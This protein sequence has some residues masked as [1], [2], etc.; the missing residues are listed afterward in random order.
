RKGHAKLIERTAA[1]VGQRQPSARGVL[2]R[3]FGDTHLAEHKILTRLIERQRRERKIATENTARGW[4]SLPDGSRRPLDEFGVSFSASRA[5]LSPLFTAA[6]V[7]VP[8]GGTTVQLAGHSSGTNGPSLNDWSRADADFRQQISVDPAPEGYAVRLVFDHAEQ[9]AR[10]R[11]RSDGRDITL[12]YEPAEGPP[13][14]LHRVLDP[15]SG[16]NRADTT[17]WFR[18][19]V[20]VPATGSTDFAMY[21]DATADGFDDPDEVFPFFDDFSSPAAS[22]MRWRVFSGDGGE[23]SNGRL[24]FDGV[25]VRSAGPIAPE[26]AR[27]E[28][29]LR[30]FDDVPN[31]LAYLSVG[32]E[33]QVAPTEFRFGA[34]LFANET[35]HF[36][37]VEDNSTPIEIRDA[38]NDHV[39]AV[40]RRATGDI[41]FFQDG[42][43]LASLPQV[44]ANV[45]TW[46]MSLINR[47]TSGAS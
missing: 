2:G 24:T 41:R 36:A 47:G 8:A 12:V 46:R 43:E 11:S 28:A 5:S 7:D 45:A 9:V 4:L 42:R 22:A 18:T 23:V 37:L 21:F 20:V 1:P 3:C 13:V 10:N 33:F 35:G 38:Q 44:P 19:P 6:L 16:W 34:G 30:L 17:V 25:G 15:D 27:W 31:G 32:A 29:R 40:D 14:R 39:F 26:G